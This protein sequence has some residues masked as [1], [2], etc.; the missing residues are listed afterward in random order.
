M[1]ETTF[2]EIAELLEDLD[3][4]SIPLEAVVAAMRRASDEH[5]LLV[6]LRI[7]EDLLDIGLIS[8]GQYWRDKDA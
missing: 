6:N 7:I 8:T 3:K 4:R 1:S 2:S 5:D